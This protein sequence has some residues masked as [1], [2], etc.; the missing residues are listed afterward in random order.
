M[1]TQWTDDPLE[2]YRQAHAQGGSAFGVTLW[3][4]EESQRKRFRVLREMV[5]LQGKRVLDAGCSR[6]DLAV[7]LLEQGPMYGRYIGVDGLAG[8]IEFAKQRGLPDAE[9]LTADLLKEPES[10]RTGDPQVIFLSGTL[11]TMDLP[12]ALQLLESCWEAASETLVFNFLSDLAGPKAP[13][14]DYPASRLPTVKLLEW[15]AKRA[16]GNVMLRQDYFRQG[17]DATV[18]MGKG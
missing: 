6:G 2:P 5:Y 17:H 15:A 9:F 10:L 11:N 14:Q 1:P 8:V 3:N 12:T 7:Y 16:E 4:T 13:A 18:V